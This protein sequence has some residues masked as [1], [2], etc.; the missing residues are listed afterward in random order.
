MDKPIADHCEA[1]LDNDADLKANLVVSAKEFNGD[2]N[3]M[4]DD[5]TSYLIPAPSQ[6]PRDPLNLPLYRKLILLG[7]V[8]L[9]SSIGLTMVSGLGGILGIFIPEYVSQG[10]GVADI[11]HLMT[12][13]T[14]FMGLGNLVGMP[15]ALA[16]GRRPVYLVSCI[17]MVVAGVLCVTQKSY[18]W[19][20][21]ARMTM[22]LAAGQSEALCPLMVQEITFL[23]ERS[24]YQ[25]VFSALGNILTTVLVLLT[26]YIAASIGAS[27]W[28]GLLTGLAGLVLVLS[29]LF[30]PET[31]Y[32]RPLAAYQGQATQV[33]AFAEQTAVG[34]DAEYVVTR[35]KTTDERVLD[36]V[37]YAPRTWA[38]DLRIVV[39]KPD[40][41]E[42]S[43]TVAR[44]LTVMFFPDMLWG[45]LLNGLTLGVNV[46]IGTT[47]GNILSAPP[48]SWPAQNISFAN[49]GQIIVSL[50]SLVVLGWGSDALV[51]FFARRN[52]GVHQPQYR[53]VPLIFPAIVGT[54]ASILYGQAAAH[55]QHIHWFAIVFA[56]NAYYFAFLGANQSAIVYALDAYPT[57]S[58]PA[59]VVICAYRG[60]L[61]FGTSYAVQPLI[62]LRGY[63][64]AFLVYGVL[65]GVLAA[66][67]IPI[68]F[69]SARI[70]AYC[71]KYTM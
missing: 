64:G 22:G 37:R 69:F 1:A 67:G 63:D 11:T 38:S 31:K 70:R 47:Y 45:F 53:L 4:P 39:H 33:G 54:M 41:H 7:V 59:L 55:P 18:S 65:T 24:R 23:H 58:G 3:L 15:L 40:W 50:L 62:D 20:L 27:G 8:S 57:R 2:V 16:V 66:L 60:I 36:T 5:G 14:L 29:V 49:A 35:L 9:F 19:H 25:M 17:I 13:P 26:S 12:Y 56:L 68:Y 28:Y 46:A 43:R 6:D 71:T 48:Y 44:M 10:Y 32:E 34:D 52:G 30:V 42:G 61:S 21:G 51:R